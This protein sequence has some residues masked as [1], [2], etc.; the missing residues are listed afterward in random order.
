MTKKS[1]A[2]LWKF[3][4]I[5]FASVF[6]VSCSD[7]DVNFQV[8]GQDALNGTETEEE[9]LNPDSTDILQVY[10]GDTVIFRNTSQPQENISSQKW[11]VDGDELVDERFN[12]I[13]EF[14]TVYTRPDR[15]MAALWVNDAAVPVRKWIEV[16]GDFE[17]F[18]E[19]LPSV[20]FIQPSGRMV[21][22]ESRT[23]KLEASLTEIYNSDSIV[24]KVN[25]DLT[26][27]NFDEATG[28]LE[29]E[30]RLANGANEVELMAYTEDGSVYS[31][32]ALISYQTSR[33]SPGK[34]SAVTTTVNLNKEKPKSESE[35]DNVFSSNENSKPEP[36]TEPEPVPE[37]KTK[38]E[39]EEVNVNLTDFA[40]AG[41]RS[42]GVNEAC[43]SD[44][45]ET[46][47]FTITPSKLVRIDDF[48]VFNTVCGS[49]EI[50]VTSA[51]GE[52]LTTIET[53]TEG[54]SQ[55]SFGL[56]TDEVFLQKGVQ[57][58][59]S[60][61]PMKGNTNCGST[62]NPKLVDTKG[63]APEL[64]KRAHL[65]TNFKGKSIIHDI[66]YSY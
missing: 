39:P 5:L 24:L 62:E 9:W 15:F 29:Q 49:L 11:D 53:L 34:T 44:P 23:F 50:T 27:F 4:L 66:T 10:V 14:K 3:Q 60:L 38:S 46:Y 35:L 26:E 22:T 32:M 18:D 13:S 8:N 61:K 57:Y 37:P 56:Y 19:V 40:K 47:S 65:T 63:C 48:V 51:E 33:P 28:A 31:D 16:Q 36:K 25:G 17:V 45:V 12:G 58:T 2:T 30:L 7:V 43:L 1:S 52:L 21:E 6:V 64:R 55:I 42:D 59:F 20:S 54:K 41:Y